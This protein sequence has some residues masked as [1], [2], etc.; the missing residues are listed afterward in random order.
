MA[1]FFFI[2]IDKTKMY[3]SRLEFITGGEFRPRDTSITV[4]YAYLNAQ[5]DFNQ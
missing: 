4:Y 3:K 1:D 5:K 2:N